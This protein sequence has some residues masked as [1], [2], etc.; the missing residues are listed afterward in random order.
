MIRRWALRAGRHVDACVADAHASEVFTLAMCAARLASAGADRC[1][2]LWRADDLHPLGTLGS[3][4]PGASLFAIARIGPPADGEHLAAAGADGALRVWDVERAVVVRANRAEHVAMCAL[5]HVDDAHVLVGGGA[6]GTL[7]LLDARLSGAGRPAAGATCR[8]HPSGV[9][10]LC[11]V[12]DRP[13]GTYVFSASASGEVG[14]WRLAPSPPTDL[15]PRATDDHAVLR[16]HVGC[17]WALAASGDHI[18]S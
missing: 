18:F 12:D 2:R 6:D 7:R 11:H 13:R 15:P 1:I 8:A 17:V 14:C 16:G 10:A 5:C 3:D 9:L 4:A